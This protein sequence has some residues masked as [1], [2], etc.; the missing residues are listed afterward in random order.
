[1]ENIMKSVMACGQCFIIIL[2]YILHRATHVYWQTLMIL[3][4]II[5]SDEGGRS[6]LLNQWTAGVWGRTWRL[7]SA[8]IDC[9]AVHKHLQQCKYQ[10]SIYDH[11]IEAA[12]CSC[13]LS[14]TDLSTCINLQQWIVLNVTALLLV[15]ACD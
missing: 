6:L 8:A 15:L 5:Q 4:L 11:C 3:W 10:P 13:C 2:K 9:L 14:L 7:L 1:M 12:D